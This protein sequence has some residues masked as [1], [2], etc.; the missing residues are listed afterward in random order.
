[1]KI[2]KLILTFSVLG[3]TSL[4]ACQNN[5]DDSSSSREEQTSSTSI[6]SE[7]SSSTKK[8]DTYPKA[9]VKTEVVDYE[10]VTD[11]SKMPTANKAYRVT[12]SLMTADEFTVYNVK[13]DTEK[14]LA[15]PT[16]LTIKKSDYC[17]TYE[18]VAL[19]YQAFRIAP[20]NYYLYNK[21]DTSNIPSGKEYRA[22]QIFTYGSYTGSNSYT[23]S[24]GVFNN[25]KGQY[26]EL[27]IALN[28]SYSPKGGRG[29]GR[30]V[31][32]VDGIE[33]YEENTPVCYFTND[34]YT[35]FSEFYNYASGW[36]P[37]FPGL[38]QQTSPRQI[39]TSVSLNY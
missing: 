12:P 5:N 3:A 18:T 21:K 10:A 26:L 33:D 31:V 22:Y 38:R 36:G 25:R 1:M 28:D 14:Y 6:S 16:T 8:E 2:N 29:Q 32:V 20:P 24:L 7:E 37:T 17:Y 13:Y 39:P 35:T 19:Y 11:N 15:Y 30:V 23:E 4:F 34:H 9:E 27:D